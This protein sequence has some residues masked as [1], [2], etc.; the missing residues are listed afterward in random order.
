MKDQF[1]KVGVQLTE[2]QIDELANMLTQRCSHKT[3]IRINSMIVYDLDTLI[4]NISWFDRFYISEHDN[5]VHYCAGQ[6]YPCEIKSIR[7]EILKKYIPIKQ[8]N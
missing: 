1:F 8:R 3:K 4:N 5:D 2:N 7:N 6:S